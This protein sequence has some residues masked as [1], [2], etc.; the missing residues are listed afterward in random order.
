MAKAITNQQSVRAVYEFIHRN[1]S[2]LWGE[3]SA[4][5]LI[6][7]ENTV[8]IIAVIRDITDHIESERELRESSRDLELY[9]SLLRH[10][11]GNDLQVI[12][13]QTQG[14]QV[15]HADD[16][17]LTELA[18]AVSASALRMS[19]VLALFEPREKKSEE[20]IVAMLESCALQAMKAHRGMEVVIQANPLARKQE[21]AG[22]R[23]LPMVFDNLLRNSAQ[24]TE[25]D[26]KVLIAV[27][28]EKDYVQIDVSDDGPGIP[29][30]IQ[31]KLFERGTSTKGGGLG[32][33]LSKRVIEHY[34]GSIEV[35]THQKSKKGAI[36][37]IKLKKV[38]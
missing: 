2:R 1:G 37:R 5:P 15:L 13:A 22:G 25:T 31:P 7:N 36:F 12:L 33:Y 21:I 8:A 3:V 30:E 18:E 35:L 14:A 32:L 24:F 29:K 34:G 11:L 20:N 28:R 16:I 19:Q 27:T 23:L 9:T 17:R 6:V 10:D 26:V 38:Q 4:S